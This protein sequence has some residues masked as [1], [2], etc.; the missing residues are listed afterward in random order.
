MAT[1][2]KFKPI[3]EEEKKPLP[4][5]KSKIK[6]LATKLG[7]SFLKGVAVTAGVTLSAYLLFTFL[8]RNGVI[9]PKHTKDEIKNATDSK[10]NIDQSKLSPSSKRFLDNVFG[11]IIESGE[12][13]VIKKYPQL[14]DTDTLKKNIEIVADK[15][16]EG[17]ID[18]ATD[19]AITN[20]EVHKDE[21]NKLAKDAAASGAAGA[22]S[23]LLSGI[24]GTAKP[25]TEVKEK[26]PRISAQQRAIDEATVAGLS[27]GST[28]SRSKAKLE[29]PEFY[30]AMGFGN[31]SKYPRLRKAGKYIFIGANAVALIY[32]LVNHGTY[33]NLTQMEYVSSRLLSFSKL[34]GTKLFDILYNMKIPGDTNGLLK[35]KIIFTL[36]KYKLITI[37]ANLKPFFDMILKQQKT[38]T[39]VGL[40]ESRQSNLLSVL[41]LTVLAKMGISAARSN[42]KNGPDQSSTINEINEMEEEE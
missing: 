6:K 38:K 24:W 26:K 28:R 25:P 29:E 20:L 12:A 1:R 22:R 4:F 36:Y 35:T 5:P 21:L 3:Q 30:D 7:K 32:F 10:G 42:K 2:I 19:V 11:K 31:E 27:P 34:I 37:S 8:N 41:L 17:R 13:S 14:S 9:I 39:F 15:F 33:L 16:L 18:K 23:G 40:N